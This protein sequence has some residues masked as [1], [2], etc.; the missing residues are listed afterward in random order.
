MIALPVTISRFA[1]DDQPG[2]VECELSDAF[3]RR[4]VFIEKIPVVTEEEVWRDSSYPRG[5]M[6]ACEVIS[7]WVDEK[8]RSLSK[9]D[10]SRPW[11]IESKD[12]QAEFVVLTEALQTIDKK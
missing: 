3:G 10:T 12:G 9:I 4:H 7:S 1:D 6:F 11:G 5:G 2:W 8:G